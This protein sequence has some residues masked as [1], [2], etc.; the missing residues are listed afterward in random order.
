[1]TRF[2]GDVEGDPIPI[3]P[4]QPISLVAVPEGMS[5]RAG[6]I[7]VDDID[8]LIVRLRGDEDDFSAGF[9]GESIRAL[10]K[11]DWLQTDGRITREPCDSTPPDTE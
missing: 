3:E 11:S 5:G 4:G 2:F 7:P 10:E 8:W 6:D 9:D 1:M